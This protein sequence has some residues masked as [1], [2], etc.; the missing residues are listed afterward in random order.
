MRLPLLLWIPLAARAIASASPG[1]TIDEP[2]RRNGVN[3]ALKSKESIS[4]REPVVATGFWNGYNWDAMQHSQKGVNS[5]Q[6]AAD[7]MKDVKKALDIEHTN[8]PGGRWQRFDKCILKY[9]RP[10]V[11]K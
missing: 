9:V 11:L 7:Y 8:D 2:I 4:K 3:A 10:Q 6:A 5:A 1:A